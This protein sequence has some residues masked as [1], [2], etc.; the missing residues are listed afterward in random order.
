MRSLRTLALGFFALAACLHGQPQ[1]QLKA[2]L[3]GLKQKPPAKADLKH[4]ISSDIMSMAEKTHEPAILDL[5]MFV[6]SLADVLP[7]SSLHDQDAG[8]LAAD[9][10]KVMRSAG[11]ST[12][13]F[14]DTLTDFR[15]TLVA[16][17]VREASATRTAKLL[18]AI[19]RK[20]RGPDD[21]P[22]DRPGI[23]PRWK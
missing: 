11:T 16:A 14:F 8:R 22:L 6:S 20:V 2:D 3:L 9:V 10:F 1:Q 23:A 21:T 15:D 19:G 5:Q 12:A 7:G 4:Q 18:D 17:G 13:G